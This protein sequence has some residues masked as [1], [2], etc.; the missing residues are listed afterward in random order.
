MFRVDNIQHL[1]DETTIPIEYHPFQKCALLVLR[2][3]E[4]ACFS[5]NDLFADCCFAK[6][7][8]QIGNLV[9]FNI[10]F[11]RLPV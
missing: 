3:N 9:T 5:N 2:T 11:C 7:K 8:K 4:Q 10:F 6:M 1:I